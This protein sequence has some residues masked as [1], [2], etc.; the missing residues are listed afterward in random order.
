MTAITLKNNDIINLLISKQPNVSH[1]DKSGHTALD[2][3]VED[4]QTHLVQLLVDNGV[5]VNISE[6]RGTSIL[7]KAC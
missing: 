5:D 2:I 7:M 1:R 4:K 6:Y 3:A